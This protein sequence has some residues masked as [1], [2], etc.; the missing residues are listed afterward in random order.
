MQEKQMPRPSAATAR[1]LIDTR[2]PD[3]AFVFVDLFAMGCLLHL[4][5]QQRAGL[6]LIRE[7]RHAVEG[8][9]QKTYWANLIQQ[10]PGNELRY[11]SEI[12]AHSEV[13]ELEQQRQA[14]LCPPSE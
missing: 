2:Y 10:L 7:V 9:R 14:A 12:K 8:P 5:G 3:A 1:D 6:K 13:F 11:A 4:Q